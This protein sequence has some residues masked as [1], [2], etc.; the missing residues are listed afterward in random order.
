MTVR[1]SAS[2][3]GCSISPTR[4]TPPSRVARPISKPASCSR[5]AACRYGGVGSQ[6]LDTTVTITTVLNC[7]ECYIINTLSRGS[8]EHS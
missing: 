5:I 2:A 1:G 4:I 7:A 3:T 6:D 8:R